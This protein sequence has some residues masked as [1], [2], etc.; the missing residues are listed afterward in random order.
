MYSC[1]KLPLLFDRICCHLIHEERE[2]Q[3]I[4]ASLFDYFPVCFYLA[5]SLRFRRL[6][7]VVPRWSSGTITTRSSTW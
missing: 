6:N 3:P 7:A 4:G 5:D 2:A 1:G